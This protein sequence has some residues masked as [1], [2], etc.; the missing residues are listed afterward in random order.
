[1]LNTGERPGK[2]DYECT[3]CG[4]VVTLNSATDILPV[5]PRCHKTTY[6]KL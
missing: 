1:M 3:V 2:G 5:C 4:E 6:V